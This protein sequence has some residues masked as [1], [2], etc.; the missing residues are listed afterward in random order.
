M[1]RRRAKWHLLGLLA[2]LACLTATWPAH[3]DNLADEA[4]LEFEL[5]ADRYKAADFRGALEHF[6]ASN[7]LV[8]N[9]NVVFNIARSYEQL[10]QSADAY[11]YFT[12]ALEGEIDQA[13]RARIEEALAP[14]LPL[15]PL[16][17]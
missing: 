12:Q 8:P 2:V 4:E 13:T 15:T 17:P 1:T 3:A 6:L 11:L 9:R 5:G 16:V 7:R 14:T 10:K